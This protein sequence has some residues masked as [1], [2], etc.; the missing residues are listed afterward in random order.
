MKTGDISCTVER[1]I[2]G[3]DKGFARAFLIRN[4]DKLL[5]GTDS[6]WGSLGKKPPPEFSLIDDLDLPAEVVDKICRR[7]AER[8]FCGGKA[9]NSTPPGARAGNG[10]YVADKHTAAWGK[11]DNT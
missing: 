8:L 7:N 1:S 11:E 10:S 6:G 2:I 3:R 9:G 5:F 4:A